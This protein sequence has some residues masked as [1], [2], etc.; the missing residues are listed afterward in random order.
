VAPTCAVRLRAIDPLPC[1]VMH[2]R[3]ARSTTKSGFPKFPSSILPRGPA[4]P[5]K[6]FIFSRLAGDVSICRVRVPKSVITPLRP[7]R[8]ERTTLLLRHPVAKRGPVP[9]GCGDPA[10]R[11]GTASIEVFANDAVHYAHHILLFYSISRLDEEI[12]TSGCTQ[13][14]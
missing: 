1:C 5:A 9:V 7:F 10:F 12:V 14:S 6:T 4:P 3:R 8:K 13:I 2:A 11:G